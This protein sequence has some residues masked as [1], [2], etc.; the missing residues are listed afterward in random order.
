MAYFRGASKMTMQQARAFIEL[1]LK[2]CPFCGGL[3]QL[4]P[5]VGGDSYIECRDCKAATRFYRTVNGA[6]KG[7]NRRVGR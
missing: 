2:S 4:R 7:W 5:G 3:A 6:Q 1:S